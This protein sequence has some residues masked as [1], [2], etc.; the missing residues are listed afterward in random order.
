MLLNIPHYPHT[1]ALTSLRHLTGDYRVV[2]AF[3]SNHYVLN[4][5]TEQNIMLRDF[6]ALVH[7]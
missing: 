6:S 5:Y 2:M 7:K 3:I 1:P 4:A